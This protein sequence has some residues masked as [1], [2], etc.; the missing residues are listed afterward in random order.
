[1]KLKKLIMKLNC[2]SFVTI[3]RISGNVSLKDIRI[4]TAIANHNHKYV[5]MLSITFFQNH[6]FVYT[7]PIDQDIISIVH[8]SF[9]QFDLAKK[10]QF[11]CHLNRSINIQMIHFFVDYF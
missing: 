3:P 10:L 4:Q 9:K 5:Y 2:F 8:I 6:G 7:V 11:V 1:M